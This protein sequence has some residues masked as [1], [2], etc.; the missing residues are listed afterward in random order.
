LE[1]KDLI[2]IWDDRDIESGDKW[3]G[4]IEA[5]LAA[6]KA[7]LLLVS[8]D[9]INSDFIANEELP[10][11]LEAANTRGVIIL[12]VAVEVST[13]EDDFPELLEIE[14]M[15]TDPEQPLSQLDAKELSREF[16][17]IYKKIK[18]VVER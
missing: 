10:K 18:A 4:K 14:A 2:K 7:A 11:L 9:F 3:Q 16:K 15:N 13:V 12:W 8:Q 1:K 5:S 6:A 17:E